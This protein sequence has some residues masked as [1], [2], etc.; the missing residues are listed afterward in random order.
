MSSQ[1]HTL[2]KRRPKRQAME[3]EQDA[4]RAATARFV[5][6]I[7]RDMTPESVA[8]LRATLTQRGVL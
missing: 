7:C 8:R 5:D 3:R 4:T 6:S 2:R 1:S